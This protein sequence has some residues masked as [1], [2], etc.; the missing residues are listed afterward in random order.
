MEKTFDSVDYM[1]QQREKLSVRLG[2]MS[3]DEL[4]DSKTIWNRI[5]A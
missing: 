3:K 5:R 1:R 4:I 2:K